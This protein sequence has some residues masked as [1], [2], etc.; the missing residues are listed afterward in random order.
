MSSAT[1]AAT[2][3]L[4]E[5]YE[6]EIRALDQRRQAS[7]TNL[8]ALEQTQAELQGRIA[9]LM[10]EMKTAEAHVS[11]AHERAAV[12]VTSA[13]RQAHAALTTAQRQAELLRER[14]RVAVEKARAAFEGMN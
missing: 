11:E 6:A 9:V 14:G 8:K 7:E 1:L 2:A 10:D 13:E 5:R 3:G 12:I 4:F